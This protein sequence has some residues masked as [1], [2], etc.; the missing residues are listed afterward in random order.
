MG[1]NDLSILTGANGP[2]LSGG[3]T[4]PLAAAKGGD[5]QAAV[6][7]A[8]KDFESVLVQKLMEE[9]KN[10][11]PESGLTEDGASKQMQ[12]LFW[13]YM[14]QT[15]GQQGGLGLWKQMVRQLQKPGANQA[16]ANVETLR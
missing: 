14:G 5:D 6:V 1:I 7:K 13:L 11:I 8:A 2:S 10:T 12:D 9:M 3:V 16:G 15:V 4:S